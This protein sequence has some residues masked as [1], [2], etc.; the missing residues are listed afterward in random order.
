LV[1]T[2]ALESVPTYFE[3]VTAIALNAFAEA[4]IE[5]AI[6]ET[7]LGGRFDATT[8]ARAEIVGIT[9]IDY[10][11][12]RMLGDT[13]AEIASEKAAIIRED[14]PVVVAP[15]MPEAENV[16]LEKCRAVGVEPIFVSEDYQV[17]KIK[18]ENGDWQLAVKFSTDNDVYHD[19]ILGLAGRHQVT[20][21]LVAVSLAEILRD[22]GFAIEKEC[23]WKGLKKARHRGRLEFYKGILFDG[24]HNA[25][26]A[27]ALR[28]YL[29]E[30]VEK[31][32][33]M[34]F[35]IMR[36]KD[37]V[38]V[39]RLLI[40]KADRLILTRVEG[41]RSAETREFV[42]ILPPDYVEENFDVKLFF[43]DDAEKALKKAEILSP[44]EN[45]ILVTGSLYLI[46]E[47]QKILR[48]AS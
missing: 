8:A 22:F 9:P 39:A 10:D 2:G 15:Q 48:D 40:P 20:N 14:S 46:G 6:L 42:E 25:G 33:T 11:H 43:A 41:L 31:P 18:T 35:A 37:I 38:E 13:L 36:D 44:K 24:A 3:Q 32:I 27:R 47:A 28:E 7:G 29:D 21:A 45:L 26:G 16:I 5:L 34:I 30:F 12:Q 4:K 19:M 1:E 23:F 17:K